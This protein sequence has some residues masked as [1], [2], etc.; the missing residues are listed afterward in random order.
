MELPSPEHLEQ[1]KEDAGPHETGPSRTDE[2][3]D[4]TV[5]FFT[6][7]ALVSSEGFR[8]CIKKNECN[9]TCAKPLSCDFG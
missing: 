4:R 5:T 1:L 7:P 2:E 8:K 6:C 3:G 9:G